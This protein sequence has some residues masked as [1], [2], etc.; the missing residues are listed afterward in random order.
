MSTALENSPFQAEVGFASLGFAIVAFLAFKGSF[1]MRLAALIAPACFLWGNWPRSS[2]HRSQTWEAAQHLVS[3]C[4]N[5]IL[6]QSRFLSG[7]IARKSHERFG[8]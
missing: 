1:N 5:P 8:L 3:V 2:L 4:L 6:L 7:S